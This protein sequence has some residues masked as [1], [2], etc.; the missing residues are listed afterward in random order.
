MN[1]IN[2]VYV[3]LLNTNCNLP[4]FVLK[5]RSRRLNGKNVGFKVYKYKIDAYNMKIVEVS[6]EH[7]SLRKKKKM[8]KKKKTVVCASFSDSF[9]FYIFFF[10]I[11]ISVF[12]FHCYQQK[13][14]QCVVCMIETFMKKILFL[15]E[16][17][18]SS[19]N[20][21][22]GTVFTEKNK[23]RKLIFRFYWPFSWL[24]KMIYFFFTQ[25]LR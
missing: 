7:R 6:S 4:S 1:V 13:C 9:F 14:L 21:R 10:N 15:L 24:L 5:I 17:N 23:G 12:F 20:F 25:I 18:D 11:H 22:I 8:K 19:H 2:L 3:L 16:W